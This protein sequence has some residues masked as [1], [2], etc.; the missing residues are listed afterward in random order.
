[1]STSTDNLL[2][3]NLPPIE[4]RLR[5]DP[6]IGLMIFDPLRD[7]F[8]ALTPE[9]WVRQHFTAW[10]VR[11][12]G[13]PPAMMANEVGLRLNGTL[14]RCDTVVYMP[15]GMRPLAIVEYK[16]PHIPIT[17]KVIDQILRYNIVLQVP[18]LLVSNGRKVIGMLNR[19][20]GTTEYL[21]RIPDYDRLREYAISKFYTL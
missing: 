18:C 21:D 20:E 14:R 9:E 1:M 6:A 10:L 2:P 3:L 5:R 15:Q 12:Y 11:D 19:R 4:P 17:Q 7:K 16:A 8:V 13:F